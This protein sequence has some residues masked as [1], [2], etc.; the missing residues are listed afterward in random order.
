[1]AGFIAALV[2]LT[3]YATSVRGD[4]SVFVNEGRQLYEKLCSGCHGSVDDSAKA[5]RSMNRIRS[6]IRIQPTHQPLSKLSDED[7]LLIAMA[8][9]EGEE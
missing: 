3:A 4:E 1:M 9:K 8:L 5:G 2:V 6:A 7:I